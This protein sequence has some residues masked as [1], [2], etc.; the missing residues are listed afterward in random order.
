MV[1]WLRFYASTGGVVESIAGQETK[2]PHARWY[3][4]KVEKKQKAKQNKTKNVLKINCDGS[5]GGGRQGW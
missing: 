2:I 3:D 1:Q 5:S 4:Q